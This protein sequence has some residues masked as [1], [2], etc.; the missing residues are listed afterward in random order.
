MAM[1]DEPIQIRRY[2]NRRFYARHASKYV[3]LQEIE[4]MIQ[5]GKTVE[6]RD[7]QS[8]EDL[9]RAV[10]AQMV[11]KQRPDKTSLFPTAML[12]FILRSNDVTSNFLSD[13]FRH[14]L[15]YLDYLQRHGGG[16]TRLTPPMHWIEAWLDSVAPQPPERPTATESAELDASANSE[17]AAAMAQRIAELEE[18]IRQLE[19][20]GKEAER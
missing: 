9:T 8:G 6:I 12:H 1:T 14:S 19:T 17:S 2:P 16:E 7:S 18:R 10:L 5:A 4:S 15:T 3:S 13:Y 11:L 20:R